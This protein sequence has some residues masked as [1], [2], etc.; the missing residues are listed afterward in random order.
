MP[1]VENSSYRPPLFL[2]NAHLQTSLPTLFRKVRGFEYR[3]ERIDTP[4]G[5]FL[6]LD[7]SETGSKKVCILCHGL[8]S[9]S[10]EPY[11]MGMVRAFNRRDWDAVAMNFRGCSGEPNRHLR[12]YHSGATDDLQTV[13]AHIEGLSRYEEIVVVG[14]SLGGNLALKYI[15]ERGG[16]VSPILSGAAAVSVP[17]D[18]ESCSGQMAQWENRFYMR[19]FIKKLN[20]KMEIK[21]R[22]PEAHFRFEEFLKMTTF[23]E[24]DDH[25]TGPVHGF[26]DAVD[27]WN[28]CSCRQ[29][30]HDIQ[31]PTLLINA[32]DDP[33]LTERCHPTSEA[34]EN[35]SFYFEKPAHGGHVGFMSR[36]SNGEYWHEKRVADFLSV[37]PD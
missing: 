7:W 14:F 11:M 3:R 10:G 32:E 25:Y 27:Y 17:C 31:V 37:K 19:R 1:F 15:G 24:F 8:E 34:E 28:R 13:V 33:F 5:D 20:R 6:D 4:D 30:L 35:P 18:L 16:N 22:F 2:K 12:S 23:K 26:K 36:N 29:F 9:N 21:C